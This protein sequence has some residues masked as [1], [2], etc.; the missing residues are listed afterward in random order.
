MDLVG[1]LHILVA[2]GV[3]TAYIVYITATHNPESE[4]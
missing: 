1:L 3:P 4:D 2:V